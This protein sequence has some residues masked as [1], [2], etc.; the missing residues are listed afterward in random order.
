MPSSCCDLALAFFG[1]KAL[2]APAEGL[3][4][5][6]TIAIYAQF[7]AARNIPLVIALIAAIFV[8]D[9]TV[10]ATLL[11][12]GGLIQIADAMI[13]ISIGSASLIISP[14]ILATLYFLS[15]RYWFTHTRAAPDPR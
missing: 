5:G 2:T 11:G 15:A 8:R 3:P 1:V 6:T 13:G 9:R 12:L 14:L 7:M 10:L 4:A